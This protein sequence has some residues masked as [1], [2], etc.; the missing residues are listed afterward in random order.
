MISPALLKAGLESALGPR[1]AAHL[2][3]RPRPAPE[4]VPSGIPELDALTGGLPRGAIA[5]LYGPDSSGRTSLLLSILAEATA[6]EEVCALV[7]AGDS[8]DPASAAAA[9]ADLTRLLWIRCAGNPEHALKAADLLIQGG[10]FG[11]VAL[12]LGE[13]PA[14]IARRVPLASWFRFRRAIENTPTALIVLEREP[15]VKSCASLMLE[16]K[17]GGA[18]WSGAPGCSQ[19]LRGLRVGAAP[20]KPVRPE[21]VA[22]LRLSALG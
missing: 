15:S 1:F 12:D 17:R 6:R 20:R 13:V 18:E 10:G 19:L 7:D 2:S 3:L 9:G 14:R 21:G 5:D 11:L 8:L 22:S 16:M 4:L